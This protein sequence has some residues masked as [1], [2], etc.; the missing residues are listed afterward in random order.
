MPDPV[1]KRSSK[2]LK[3]TNAKVSKLEAPSVLAGP[4]AR[5]V[6]FDSEVKGFGVVV[7]PSGTKT[8][9]AERRV[10]GKKCRVKIDSIDKLSAEDA[11]KRAQ[12]ILVDMNKGI[13]PT[14]EKKQAA[15]QAKAKHV[16]LRDVFKR[17]KEEKQR[18]PSTIESYE[19]HMNT[20]FSDWL[21]K[22]IS[23]ITEDMIVKKYKELA[24][25][26][27]KRSSQLADDDSRCGR[28]GHAY[29]NQA[30]RYLRSILNY[31]S[32]SYKDVK[33]ASLLPNNPVRR[34]SQAKLWVEVA[35]RTSYITD[36]DLSVW[37]QAVCKQDDLV[38]DY[39]LLC[40]FTGLRKSEAARLKWRYVNF[41]SRSLDIPKE[42]TKNGKPHQLPLP[43]FLLKLLKERFDTLTVR[44]ISNDEFVFRGKG[45]KGHIVE[46]KRQVEK[47]CDESVKFTIHDL[48]RT[49]ATLAYGLDIPY[50]AL[51]QLM[52]H[53]N[54]NDVTANYTQITLEK[55]RVPMQK[56]CDRFCELSKVESA[57]Q[58]S[59]ELLKAVN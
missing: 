25:S 20:S 28:T 2:V 41:K 30:M 21:D 27:A 24:A 35:P 8:Y 53:K 7:F 22:P 11:R 48:R 10:A 12:E 31:A 50:L 23:Y 52:N 56:I 43:T 33:G 42:E 58:D 57:G 49:F 1:I 36:E 44:N 5:F 13:N 46:I 54:K 3:L 40:L 38:R 34:L 45:P 15:E 9:I 4:N 14:K 6:Y 29:A 16:T 26:I 37:C 59:A 47:I 32:Y 55:L 51:K 17:Y 19:K 18:R 39:L